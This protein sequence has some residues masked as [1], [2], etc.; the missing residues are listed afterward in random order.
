MKNIINY[1]EKYYLLFVFISIQL[2]MVSLAIIDP[3]LPLG[4]GVVV[5]QA[6]YSHLLMTGMFVLGYALFSCFDKK[7]LLK[8]QAT[9]EIAC[10]SKNYIAFSLGLVILGVITSVASVW[11][12]F[13]MKEYLN[14]ILE[15]PH[16]IG[17]VRNIVGT[18]GLPGFIKVFNY[19]PLA[20]LFVNASLFLYTNNDRKKILIL[21]LIALLGVFVKVFFL[22]D[23]ISLLGALSVLI[24]L[25]YKAPRKFIYV[26]CVL[27]VVLLFPLW[28]IT[29]FRMNEMSILDFL[30]LY[31]H[32]GMVNYQLLIEHFHNW[33]YGLNTFL[34][35]VYFMGKAAGIEVD[36]PKAPVSVWD[37]PQYF[38]GYLYM[39][40]G[41]FSYGV[42]LVLGYLLGWFQRNVVLRKKWAVLFFFIVQFLVLS[43]IVIPVCRATE[44]WLLIMITVISG[45]L[46]EF[47]SKNYENNIR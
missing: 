4:E 9:I 21:L 18:S 23:R 5:H 26:L 46:I 14:I 20:V 43:T 17:E 44:F 32:L 3:V 2:L 13:P 37:N 22:L 11:V 24:C 47:K 16:R 8:P 10:V 1:K 6:I 41:W 19:S 25:G 15:S 39:D 35:P 42:V 40:F 27:G 30:V 28:F 36:V 38:Y 34:M 12:V 7:E 31:A 33:S 29:N 45:L